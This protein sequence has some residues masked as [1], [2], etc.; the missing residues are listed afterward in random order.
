MTEKILSP[1]GAR[2]NRGRM[3]QILWHPPTMIGTFHRKKWP[4]SFIIF[5][6]IGIFQKRERQ[7]SD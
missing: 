7:N 4:P 1:I 3:L 5:Y 2:N 6:F